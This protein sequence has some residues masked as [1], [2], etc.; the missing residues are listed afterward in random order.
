MVGSQTVFS[1][2]D[3]AAAAIGD[4]TA[5]QS[6]MPV[7]LDFDGQDWEPWQAHDKRHLSPNSTL[8]LVDP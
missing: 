8:G 1:I 5:L 6:I 7:H 2:L 4:W 3:E